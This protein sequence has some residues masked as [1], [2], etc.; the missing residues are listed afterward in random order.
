MRHL[1]VTAQSWSLKCAFTISRGSKKTADIVYVEISDGP[2]KGHGEAVP[3]A[4]YGESVHSVI[5][6]IEDMR[7]AVIA[8]MTS[9]ALLE[10][11]KP[12]AARN[13]LDC[14]LWDLEC[15]INNVSAWQRTGKTPLSHMLTAFTISLDTAEEMAQKA[16][17]A[18]NYPVLKLKLGAED[19]HDEMRLNLI[20]KACPHT[21]LIVDA[22]E[23]WAENN[24]EALLAHCAKT[25]IELVEQ[26]L[27][28]GRD[29][30]LAHIAHP[31]PICADESC[32]TS[33]R[34][35]SLRKKYDWVNIKLDKTGG[36]THALEMVKRAHALDFGV[37][38]GCMVGTSLAMAPAL[39]LAQ[40]ASLIDL[41]GPLWLAKDREDGLIYQNGQIL[42]PQ[43]PLW[44]QPV[45]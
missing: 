32:H 7:D 25:K 9:A 6:Q 45:K 12:G 2:Y 39:L 33:E 1:N 41:D 13:A 20:R 17:S 42:N 19:G 40:E 15:K 44:G 14:A 22:N 43:T 31:V 38:I 34:L 27:P 10:H 4:R 36:L 3:Y 8:G 18:S 30:I 16:R 28:E 35:G 5:S 37:M 29:E 26:P 21:R 23:G 24:I 11:M